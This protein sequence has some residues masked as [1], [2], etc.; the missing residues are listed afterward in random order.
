[1]MTVGT[2]TVSYTTRASIGVG[3]VSMAIASVIMGIRDGDLSDAWRNETNPARTENERCCQNAVRN[4][5]K[6]SK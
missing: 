5:L 4:A 2:F 6:K 1:M 3:W